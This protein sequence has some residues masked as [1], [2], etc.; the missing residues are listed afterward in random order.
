MGS[1]VPGS[2]E[3][4]WMEAGRLKLHGNVDD[5]D[6]DDVMECLAL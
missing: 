6:V 1:E 4:E 3:D 5:G 2:S